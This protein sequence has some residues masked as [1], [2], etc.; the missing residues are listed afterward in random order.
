MGDA[1]DQLYGQ[2]LGCHT[3]VLMG[4][5]LHQISG[6]LWQLDRWQGKLPGH[7]KIISS[8]GDMLDNIPFS[9]ETTRFRVLLS[10]R[11]LGVRVLIL[12]TILGQVLPLPGRTTS[13]E[14]QSEWLLDSVFPLLAE[15]ARTCSNVF[16]ISGDLLAASRNNQN[17]LGAWWF[18]CYYSKAAAWAIHR[19][20]DRLVLLSDVADE[21]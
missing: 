19:D 4:E 5:S 11:Y 9:L 3:P 13:N 15:L 6:L 17:L 18:S 21:L 14:H 8:S 10:L 16:Q 2:N 20:D 12:R 7:L 1:V